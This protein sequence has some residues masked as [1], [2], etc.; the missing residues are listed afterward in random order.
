MTRIVR[1]ANLLAD[2]IVRLEAWRKG[3]VEARATQRLNAIRRAA[4]RTKREG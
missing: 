4:N 3:S 1:E 2:A